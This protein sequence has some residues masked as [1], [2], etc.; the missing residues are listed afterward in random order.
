MAIILLAIAAGLAVGA[1]GTSY[2]LYKA[3]HLDDVDHGR[4]WGSTR[5]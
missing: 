1:G 2:L 5:F 3:F 4:G